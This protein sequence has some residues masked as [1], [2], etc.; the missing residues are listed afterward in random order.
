MMA[1]KPEESRSKRESRKSAGSTARRTLMGPGP[2]E[3]E[4]RPDRSEPAD[5]CMHER[6]ET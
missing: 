1:P 5:I 3:L 2:P 6:K 4:F